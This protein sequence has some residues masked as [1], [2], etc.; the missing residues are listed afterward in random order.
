MIKIHH[1]LKDIQSFAQQHKNLVISSVKEELK[2][3]KSDRSKQVYK[4]VYQYI[5][6]NLESIIS[7]NLHKL[8]NHIFE[9]E[10]LFLLKIAGK[11]KN[12]ELRT[13]CKFSTKNEWENWKQDKLLIPKIRELSKAIESK[14]TKKMNQNTQ[15]ALNKRKLSCDSFLANKISIDEL[16]KDLDVDKLNKAGL[17]GLQ[18]EL[19]NLPNM[20][21]VKVYFELKKK[22]TQKIENAFVIKKVNKKSKEQKEYLFKYESSSEWALKLI[23][24]LN[25]NSCL[26][27]NRQ[28]ISVSSDRKFGTTLDHFYDKA[29]YPYLALSFYNL[30]P[31]CYACNSQLK[32]TKSFS[33]HTHLHPYE[34]GFEKILHFK[35]SF[36]K[37]EYLIDDH[38]KDFDIVLEEWR[39]TKPDA[40][41]LEKAKKN[42]EDFMLIEQYQIH[43]EEV[44]DLLKLGFRYLGTSKSFYEGWD[45]LFEDKN[46]A[47][48]IMFG[49]LFVDEKD[50]HK[51]VLS[52]LKRDIAIEYFDLNAFDGLK[53]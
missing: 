2:N 53:K 31:S 51:R 52:K 25:I 27:C 47:I 44:R 5:E 24:N 36:D 12:I 20:G 37:L 30:V 49:G 8:E 35:T 1:S 43:K 40:N 28:H 26:Y 4:D 3:F 29:T 14:D 23:E 39:Y 19:N 6:T 22:C 16:K 21:Y 13:F 42:V 15:K 33:L 9:I 7:S 46:E 17:K 18:K 34:K 50:L 38:S 45:G 11:I 41:D 48:R 10:K 32:N